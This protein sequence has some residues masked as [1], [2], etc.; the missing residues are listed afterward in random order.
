[1]KLGRPYLV[2]GHEMVHKVKEQAKRDAKKKEIN[3]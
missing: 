1:V 3:K 2:T